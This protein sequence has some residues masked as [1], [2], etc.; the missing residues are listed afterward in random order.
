MC[1]KPTAV[2]GRPA[3]KAAIL[4]RC[5]LIS[6]GFAWKAHVSQPLLAQL[7]RKAGFFHAST[8]LAGNFESMLVGVGTMSPI[9]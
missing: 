3:Y 8:Y 5:R 9:P 1:K 2:M 6:T 4:A 7:S